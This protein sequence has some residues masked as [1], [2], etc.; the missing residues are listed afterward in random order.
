[1]LV[2]GTETA[3]ANAGGLTNTSKEHAACALHRWK[4][5]PMNRY[6]VL[7][8]LVVAVAV[9]AALYIATQSP[10]AKLSAY[11]RQANQAAIEE[12]PDADSLQFTLTAVASGKHKVSLQNIGTTDLRIAP[13]DLITTS[14]EFYDEAGTK[15]DIDIVIID[16]PS[17]A[18][19]LSVIEPTERITYTVDAEQLKFLYPGYRKASFLIAR[20]RPDAVEQSELAR[21]DL[22]GIELRSNVLELRE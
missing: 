17:G 22:A 16:P 10:A 12:R 4:R 7:L 3:N 2:T 14:F 19:R 20:Y 8:A 21:C 13:L 9:G 1:M 15:I 6:V 18:G 11:V 5:E